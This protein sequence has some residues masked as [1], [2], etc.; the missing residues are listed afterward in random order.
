MLELGKMLFDYEG[1]QNKVGVRVIF[2]TFEGEVLSFVFSLTKC[3][4][5]NMAKYFD[6]RAR[7]KGEYI[8]SSP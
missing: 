4:S 3:S 5:N 8:D 2:I 1:R 6:S 7:G